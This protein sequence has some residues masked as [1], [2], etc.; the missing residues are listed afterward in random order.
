MGTQEEMDQ[1][2]KT[3]VVVWLL[4]Q[5]DYNKSQVDVKWRI[6]YTKDWKKVW[7]ILSTWKILI[8]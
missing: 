2:A 3:H 1:W 5:L 8:K 7:I 4:W 6:A